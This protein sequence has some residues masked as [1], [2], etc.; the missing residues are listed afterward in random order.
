MKDQEPKIIL[1]KELTNEVRGQEVA[2]IKNDGSDEKQLVRVDSLFDG[3]IKVFDQN[4][5][6]FTLD[7][8]SRLVIKTNDQASGSF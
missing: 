5:Q 4:G 3:E 2:I 1:A 7:P 6:L 8:N